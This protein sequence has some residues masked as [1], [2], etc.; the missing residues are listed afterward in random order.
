MRC[1]GDARRIMAILPL[2]RPPRLLGYQN[3]YCGP[4]PYTMHL[5]HIFDTVYLLFQV[6]D[7]TLSDIFP[8]SCPGAYLS[9]PA[10]QEIANIVRFAVN[11]GVDPTEAGPEPLADSG[12]RDSGD[13]TTRRVFGRCPR[14]SGKHGR[15]FLRARRRVARCLRE[16]ALAGLL[17]PCGRGRDRP[18]DLGLHAAA[19]RHPQRNR[20]A[21]CPCRAMPD[22]VRIALHGDRRLDTGH[23]DPDRARPQCLLARHHRTDPRAA[24]LARERGALA[25]GAGICR[26]RLP[27][28]GIWRVAACGGRRRC[29]G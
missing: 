6:S 13:R 8:L 22:R 2:R 26:R 9:W 16:S 19:C 18:R 27:G 14:H 21:A 1:Y 20:A 11:Y 12:D 10:T 15:C 17:G 5:Y 24:D 4:K 28:N 25:A 3:N 23:R 7:A 29:S